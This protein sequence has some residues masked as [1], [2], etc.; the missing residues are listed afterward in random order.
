MYQMRTPRLQI[1]NATLASVADILDV[2]EQS[3]LLDLGRRSRP[4]ASPLLELC[5]RHT[6]KLESVALRVDRD[7]VAIL[8]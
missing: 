8:H 2:L 4:L 3:T 7:G 5:V 1:R 6:D